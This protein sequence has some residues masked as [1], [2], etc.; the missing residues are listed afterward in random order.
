MDM[1]LNQNHQLFSDQ[2]MALPPLPPVTASQD[3]LITSH[4]MGIRD[5]NGGVNFLEDQHPIYTNSQQQLHPVYPNYIIPNNQAPP[6]TLPSSS[7]TD[8]SMEF[9]HFLS[10]ELERQTTEM[11]AY[12]QLQV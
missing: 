7:S 1:A 5:I 10:Y 9:S 6:L 8:L 4:D 3:W 2:S 12:L 11:E